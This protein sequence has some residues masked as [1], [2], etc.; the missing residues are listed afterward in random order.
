MN[1]QTCYEMLINNCDLK[2]GSILFNR[3]KISM[4]KFL[5]DI[6]EFAISLVELG[7]K[8][9]DVLT[10]Y[11]PTCPQA[12]VGFYVCSKLGVIANIVHPL[13]PLDKLKENL[14]Q[15]KSKGLM[16][17]DILI[18]DHK[19]LVGLNQILI[20]CSI[21]NY[22]FFRKGLYYLYTKIK[23]KTCN[24]TLKYSKLINHKNK[25]STANIVTGGDFV[26]MSFAPCI[27]VEQVVNLKSFK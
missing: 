1:N 17:Y 3:H 9:G 21:A 5:K 12:L 16:F 7:F 24:H 20:S 23:S 11:L 6:E 22:V 4:N 10:I 18:K 26:M 19:E 25:N 14:L 15:T 2:K 13:L 8:K 27:V